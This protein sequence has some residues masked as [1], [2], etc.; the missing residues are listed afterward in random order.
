MLAY[1]KG[2]FYLEYLSNPVGEHI[3][4]GQTLVATSPDGRDW[5]K[6]EVVFPPYQAPPN[7]PMPG[8]SNGYMM[9]QRMGFF[10]APNDRLL[11]L[12]FYGHAENPFGRFGIGRV[13][14]EAY[15]DGTYGPIY[16]LRYTSH[17][18]W[19]ESNTS[20]P[21]YTRSTDKG[22]VEACDALLANKLITLQWWDEDRGL[23]GFYSFNES[24]SAF[25]YYV[26][27]D[28][29]VIGFWKR[30]RC[31]LSSDG[32]VTFSTP[33][34][35]PTLTM[36]GGKQWA[37]RTDDGR[38]ALA[39][40]PIVTDEH[41]YP[42]IAITSD[43]G[44]IFDD[45]VL[46]HGEVP[47]RRYY[48]KYK[49]FG[50]QYT[51]GIIESNGNPPG[52]DMWLTY[53]VN[54]EDIWVS[55]VP[56]PVKHH[57]E[58]PVTDD[59]DDMEIGGNVIDWNVYDPIWAPVGVAAF[60]S[61]KNKSLKLADKDPYDYARAVRVFPEGQSV[62]VRCKVFAKQRDAG[63]LEIDVVD[64]YGNRPVR[65]RFGDDGHISA[66]NGTE[67]VDL[68]AYKPG[69][70]HEIALTI[71]ATPYGNYSVSIDGKAALK[72]ASLAEAVLS[73]ERLS[74]RTGPYR[75]LPVRR[76]PNQTPGPD[77]SGAGEP[78]RPAAFHVDDVRVTSR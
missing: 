10:V 24:G 30:S 8:K 31:A 68:Q 57:V 20:L 74:F 25:S 66:I 3:A 59:F 77:L 32:G 65:L 15:E 76:T 35:A 53:S 70:W 72:K 23:D 11:V 43:D 49:D 9:H 12:A 7:T 62:Q 42:L 63:L 75:A 55:R 47:P 39:Y 51:R 16:F 6:P 36:A 67:S 2:K 40:N 27:K 69:T 22:F 29:K 14:R 28:G 5:S 71:D 46:V 56:V 18:D 4:P 26:R 19:N 73:V 58:G 45:M 64:R 44:V 33:V 17:A 34:R 1:W 38:Y 60:P 78:V 48:G 54:K 37:Q 13:V 50:P 61:E 52:D 41:R 21:F